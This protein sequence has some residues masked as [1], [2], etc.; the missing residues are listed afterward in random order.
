MGKH[1]ASTCDG[2]CARA[3]VLEPALGEVRRGFVSHIDPRAV[4]KPSQRHAGPP[5]HGPKI[6]ARR[7][8]R[9]RGRCRENEKERESEK[10]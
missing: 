5:G 8:G 3:V 9:G 10:E 2:Q 6:S 4:K 1:S 7:R